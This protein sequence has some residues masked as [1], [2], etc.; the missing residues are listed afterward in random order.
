MAS[1]NVERLLPLND[2][3]ERSGSLLMSTEREIYSSPSRRTRAVPY[4]ISA[5]IPP[6]SDT[7]VGHFYRLLLFSHDVEWTFL[8]VDDFRPENKNIIKTLLTVCL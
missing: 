5:S 8:P 6:A 1:V 4:L 7:V 3:A 2:A